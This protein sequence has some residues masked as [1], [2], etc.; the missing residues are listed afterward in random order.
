MFNIHNGITTQCIGDFLMF[1]F[2]AV[3]TLN[4]DSVHIYNFPY[5]QRKKIMQNSWS[6]ECTKHIPLYR[7]YTIK[8]KRQQQTN[9]FACFRRHGDVNNDVSTVQCT[10]VAILL[11][12]VCTKWMCVCLCVSMC[13][14]CEH[15]HWEIPRESEKREKCQKPNRIHNDYMYSILGWFTIPKN[16]VFRN[17]YINKSCF[18]NI[19]IGA[20]WVSMVAC[21]QT[22]FSFCGETLRRVNHCITTYEL[23]II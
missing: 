19:R 22:W 7:R 11:Y 17:A 5:F 14:K 16:M 9:A 18:E 6:A 8:T 21:W 10:P 15:F 4:F 20:V 12:F 23:R 13:N 3:F 1:L 2:H